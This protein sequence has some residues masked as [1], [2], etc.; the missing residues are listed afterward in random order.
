MSAKW[1]RSRIPD[2]AMESRMLGFLLN[3]DSSGKAEFAN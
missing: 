3:D 1:G 2:V